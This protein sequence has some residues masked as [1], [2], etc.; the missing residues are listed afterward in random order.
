ME[1]VLDRI[2]R[3]VAAGREKLQAT[4]PPPELVDAT[5][6]AAAEAP[7]RRTASSTRTSPEPHPTTTLPERRRIMPADPFVVNVARLRRALG[8]RWH[9][10]RQGPFDPTGELAPASSVDSSVPE[11]ADATCDVVLESYR[12]GCW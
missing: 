11:G 1:I 3:T 10:T 5:A 7:R 12:G 9:E 2:M 6:P 4:T 8:T